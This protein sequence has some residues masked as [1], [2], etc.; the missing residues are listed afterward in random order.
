MANDVRRLFRSL[1]L[2]HDY[3]EIRAEAA[4]AEA[5]ARWPLLAATDHLLATVGPDAGRAGEPRRR[6]HA[7]GTGR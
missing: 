3:H 1:G 6:R 2:T 4:A 7:G 5:V